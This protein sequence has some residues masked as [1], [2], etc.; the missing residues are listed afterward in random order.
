MSAV[1]IWVLFSVAC[2]LIVAAGVRAKRKEQ[3]EEQTRIQQDP[4]RAA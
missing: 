4:R 3:N 2:A 1:V